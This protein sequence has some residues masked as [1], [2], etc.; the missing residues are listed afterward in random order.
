MSKRAESASFGD[1]LF[2]HTMYCDQCHSA[3]EEISFKKYQ[4]PKC[5]SEIKIG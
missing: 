4:C 5:Y 1:L 2:N 3:M